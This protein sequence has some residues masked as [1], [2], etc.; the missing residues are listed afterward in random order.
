MESLLSFLIPLML[1][2]FL[3]LGVAEYKVTEHGR[4][5]ATAAYI[6][7]AE[8]G[9]YFPAQKAALK[10]C[11]KAHSGATAMDRATVDGCVQNIRRTTSRQSHAT[12]LL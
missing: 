1:T 4:L 6:Q 2:A 5:P 7:K 12:G 9:L 3:G 11:L 10:N 8:N